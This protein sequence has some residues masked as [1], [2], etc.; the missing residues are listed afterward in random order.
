[1]IKKRLFFL[2][3]GLI[4]GIFIAKPVLAA[5]QPTTVSSLMSV[6]KEDKQSAMYN[7]KLNAPFEKD[8]CGVRESIS[9][10]TGELVVTNTLFGLPGRGKDL[11]LSLA[12]R[13]RDA[14]LYDET[15]RS[16][17]TQNNFG[18]TVI[19]FYD[20]FD[21][22]GYWLRTGAL[23]YTTDI[24]TI[25]GE[26]TIGTEKWVFNGYLQYESGVSMFNSSG[27]ANSTRSKSRNEAA[28]Y[29]FGEGWSLNV[30][31]I[32][33]Q[34]EDVYVTLPTGKTYPADFSLANGLKDYELGDVRFSKDASTG[35]G[36]ENAAFKLAYVSGDAQYFSSRGEI[37]LE[38]DRFNNQIRYYWEDIGGK[39]LLKRVVDSVGRPVEIDYTDTVTTFRSGKR[40][41][42]VVKAP[43]PGVPG[44]YILSSFVDPA[45][46]TFQY[47][48]SFQ[49]AAFDQVGKTP[50]VNRYANLMEIRYPTG[51]RTQY[52]FGKSTKNLGSAGS[53]EYFKITGRRD[54]ESGKA[55]NQLRYQ[56][57]NEPDGYPRFK[58]VIEPDYTYSTKVTDSNGLT[59]QYIFNAKHQIARRLQQGD[60]LY[61]TSQT[62]Y[63]TTFNLPIK[64]VTRTYNAS[65]SYFEKLHTYKYDYRGN[66]IEEN[67]PESPELSDSDAHKTTYKYDYYYNL[68]TQTRYKQD[69]D[70]VVTLRN[71]LTDD[72]KNVQGM[73]L[74]TDGALF[75]RKRFTYDGYGNMKTDA[76]EKKAG[77]WITTRY[78]YDRDYKK[79]YLT[80][81]TA[82]SVKDADGNAKEITTRFS[83]D[84]ATGLKLS[85][86]NPNGAVTRFEYDKLDRVVKAILPDGVVRKNDYD[87][88]NNIL[89]TTDANNHA[90]VYD[91]D[92][93]DKLLTVVEKGKTAELVRLTY[94]LNENLITERDGNRNLKT[95]RYDQLTRILGVSHQD[96]RGTLLAETRVAYDESFTDRFGK[97][98]FKIS[99][100]Q[101]GDTKDRIVNYYFDT[102]DRMAR[103]GRMNG[104]TEEIASVKYDYLGNPIQSTDFLGFKSK[105]RYNCLGQVTQATDAEGNSAYLKYDRLGNLIASTDALGKTAYFD[106]DS[107]GRNTVTKVPYK[108]G[109]YS[110]AKVYYDNV[111]N[112]VK[113]VD[114][115]GYVA[116]NRYNLRNQ[117]TAVERI[118]NDRESN[119]TRYD[120][121]RE[122]NVTRIEKGLNS[123]TDPNFVTYGFKYDSLN[124]LIKTIDAEHKATT[125]AYDNN[126]NMT[127][128]TDRN[129][130]TIG[131]T[132]DGLD[133][134]IKK[135][136]SKDGQKNILTSTFDLLGNLKQIA[137]AA[138]TTQF[139]YD[140]LG[141]PIY[142]NYG[143]GIR[144]RYSYDSMDRIKSMQLNQGSTPEID[145]KYSYD[146]IGRLTTVNDQGKQFKYQYN[147]VSQLVKELNGVTGIESNYQYYPSGS[148]K[149]LRHWNGDKLVASYEYQYDKRGN[150]TEK[151]EGSKTTNYRYD[152]FSRIKTVQMPEDGVQ[153]YE[154]DDL[155]NITEI[156]EIQGSKISETK[157]TYDKMSR[158]LM[159]ETVNGDDAKQQRFTYDAEGNQL[160]KDEALKRNGKL[161]TS[162]AMSF[163]YNGYNQLSRIQDPDGNFA[164][165]TYNA[166]GLR[167]RKE[168]KD[169]VTNYFYDRGSIVLETDAEN[170]VKA[171]TIRGLGLIYRE[172][173]TDQATYY[174]L[175][176]AHGDVTKL[177]NATGEIVKDYEY[178]PFGRE[179]A[180]PIKAFGGDVS[181]DLWQSEIETVD[182]PF[183]Y[184]GEYR[185]EE[186]GNY[187]LRARYYDPESRRFTSED[188]PWK[189]VAQVPGLVSGSLYAF[190]E[191]NPISYTDPTGHAVDPC[192]SYHPVGA[193][194]S[195]G[196]SGSG[197]SGSSS[198]ASGN[199]GNGSGSSSSSGPTSPGTVTT[200]AENYVWNDYG[201]IIGTTPGPSYTD[202]SDAA[203][204]T[205]GGDGYKDA[206]WI[207]GG[208][209][210]CGTY[211]AKLE[212][213]LALSVVLGIIQSPSD[214]IILCSTNGE[215]SWQKY[216]DWA[217]EQTSKEFDALQ[218]VLDWFSAADRVEALKKKH[219]VTNVQQARN[220][221][222]NVIAIGQSGYSDPAQ[223]RASNI[224]LYSCG[225]KITDSYVAHCLI[226]YPTLQ[227]Q[228]IGY[229]HVPSELSFEQMVK[230]YP[231]KVR[232]M[233]SCQGMMTWDLDYGRK[234]YTDSLVYSIRDENIEQY[235]N[236][237]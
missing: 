124:R 147:A 49:E 205:H 92:S 59:T 38:T 42:R 8:N 156:A 23:Q 193:G 78:E 57:L 12:Y 65:G 237:I 54:L 100:R 153:N 18:Q 224:R 203:K 162:K 190:C 181:K 81:V 176:N 120:Y 183:R 130:V 60:R 97:E 173:E 233:Y 102:Y 202:H 25:L 209:D 94:D 198:G 131:M 232:D 5:T 151:V 14:K 55:L 231:D 39:R 149:N 90:L 225:S 218:K 33:V 105:A 72:H 61:G 75:A 212:A 86:T 230:D 53:M 215:S 163:W 165:Y 63:H 106:Y 64:E 119:I 104:G 186:T 19:A 116:K 159:S 201:E 191:N 157:F 110:I 89:T 30:P 180:G 47:R 17:D 2:I 184:S 132:Y 76:I 222:R 200:P 187:Y 210:P 192:G 28:K 139:E 46:R 221:L 101:K 91:Y 112:V 21:A 185:D 229:W 98:Y 73:E 127:E 142:V 155:N 85:E 136:N 141:R 13:S 6:L 171:K 158:L 170:M 206:P 4:A 69:K 99:V 188:Y 95:V 169:K 37:L 164:D 24:E 20:V 103:Q 50:A 177:L 204:N 122:G 167:S 84:F 143:Q 226:S 126:G 88:K 9:S 43:I 111:G 216:L 31:W 137:N 133:R 154:Y 172:S 194:G 67:H 83:Y 168:Y 77:E 93:L 44:K 234:Y 10:E 70:T 114:P 160:T 96:K 79:A 118:L 145:L 125:Y 52:Q 35:N 41:V 36:S 152:A 166:Q 161:V 179:Q 80:A 207:P 58:T 150:Q 48:Y 134:V 22:D 148:I 213:S 40:I 16:G 108:D 7:I 128:S 87:D 26:T 82:E 15:T 182:N 228:M 175:H 199:S 115:E 135:Q 107:L 29:I 227:G 140:D 34:G 217:V 62:W 196:N 223:I 32:D 236:G 146:R 178:D 27:I 56:Y 1:M 3:I 74:R 121:D 235:K 45:G 66:V 129:G 219:L 68:M 51:A 138:G 195:S 117:L 220:H 211:G 144:Q 113:T 123:W 214:N 109:Q 71:T 189:G 174:Y 197:N 208:I 11:S